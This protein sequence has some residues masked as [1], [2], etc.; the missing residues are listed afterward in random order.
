MVKSNLDSK[1]CSCLRMTIP[2]YEDRNIL[3]STTNH[4]KVK[5]HET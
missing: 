2:E 5:Y 4:E 1:K 3:R